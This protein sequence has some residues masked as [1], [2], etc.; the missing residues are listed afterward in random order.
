METEARRQHVHAVV[1]PIR[2][3]HEV[4]G[5][6]AHLPRVLELQAPIT[7]AADLTWRG[8][9]VIAVRSPVHAVDAHV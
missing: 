4:V 5:R 9:N 6:D 2:D 8:S 3:E 7:P 1:A